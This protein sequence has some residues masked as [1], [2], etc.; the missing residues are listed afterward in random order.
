MILV[1]GTKSEAVPANDRGL[2]YGDGVFRTMRMQAGV[3][4]HWPRHY[5]KLAHDCSVLRIQC[6]PQAVFE[7]ELRAIASVEDAVVKIIV[8]RGAGARG[9]RYA[10][11]APPTRIIMTAPLPSSAAGKREEDGACVRRCGLR[12]AHQP[13][14]AGVKHLNRL[15]NV[16]ARAEWADDGIAEGI[17]CDVEG[18]VVGGT[19]SNVFAVLQRELVTPGLERCGVSG[20]TRERVLEAAREHGMPCRVRDLTWDEFVAAEEIFLV[21]SVFGLWPVK[22]VDGDARRIGPIARDM[23]QWLGS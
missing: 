21:N 14:L 8:T 20:V 11:E 5:R 2:A 4:Q 23:Q 9:Y 13:A 22:E 17:L 3:A 18:R 1:N 10:A 19:M 12:L 6:P 7:D 15:E 16:L